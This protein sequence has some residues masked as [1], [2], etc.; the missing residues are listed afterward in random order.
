MPKSTSTSYPFWLGGVAASMA[1]CCT[2]PLDL[3]KVRMQTLKHQPGVKPN[4]IT[5]L[6][7]TIVESGFRS[8]YTGISASIL[9]QMSYSLVRIGAYEK[10]K[11]HL[12][13]DGRPSTGKLLLGA[14]AAGGIGGVAGNPA[15]VLLVRMTSDTLRPPEQRFNYSNALTGLVSLVRSEGLGGLFKGVG[16]NTFRAILMNGSQVCSYDLFKSSLLGSRIPVI[17]YEIR[18]NLLLHTLASCLAGTVATTVCAPADVMRSRIM[19]QSGGASPI[20]IFTHSLQK[21]GPRFLFKGW[22]PAFVR[23]GPNTVLLFVFFEQLKK[24][25]STLTS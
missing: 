21:E 8:I 13:R 1:A 18:D 17:D 6:R 20:E 9:R 3:A 24:G 22:T 16:T 14:M 15:D 25:W 2:H 11:A 5:I 7:A 10:V 4:T 19:S 23:L 12:S